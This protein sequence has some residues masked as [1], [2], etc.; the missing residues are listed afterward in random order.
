MKPSAKMENENVEGKGF[1]DEGLYFCPG[2][3]PIHPGMF[4]NPAYRH[5]RDQITLLRRAYPAWF[6]ATFTLHIRQFITQIAPHFI[7]KLLKPPHGHGVFSSY[8]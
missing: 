4:G 6:A 3:G 7:S 1:G 5:K 8:V 2:A